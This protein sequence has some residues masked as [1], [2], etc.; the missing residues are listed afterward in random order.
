[1]DGVVADAAM[2]VDRTQLVNRWS[3]AS[4][5]LGS[6]GFMATSTDHEAGSAGGVIMAEMTQMTLLKLSDYFILFED[7]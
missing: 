6:A 2:V 3:F 4:K 7:S 5:A 1:M